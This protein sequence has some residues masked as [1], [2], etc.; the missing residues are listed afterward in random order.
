[1]S[2]HRDQKICGKEMESK[3]MT[4]MGLSSKVIAEAKRQCGVDHAILSATHTAPDG[5]TRFKE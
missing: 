3:R 2:T 5:R 1:M 4:T